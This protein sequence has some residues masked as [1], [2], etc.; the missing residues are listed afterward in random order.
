MSKRKTYDKE[1]KKQ[2]VHLSNQEGTTAAQVARDLGIEPDL[3][4]KWRA[5]YKQN[6]SSAFPGKGNMPADEEQVRQLQQELAR[7]QM[8][9]DILKKALSVFARQ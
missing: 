5:A 4:Y 8:E 6:G 3:L 9:R 2:A 7:V 1:F